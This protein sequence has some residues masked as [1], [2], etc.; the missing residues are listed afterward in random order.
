MSVLVTGATG[1]LGRLVTQRLLEQDQPVRVFT[2]DPAKAQALFGPRVEI[3]GGDFADAASVAAAM[4][5]IDRLFLLS[6]IS[7]TL[8]AEQIAVAE[9]AAAAGVS[10]IVKISGSDWTIAYPGQSISGDAH[11]DVEWRLRALPLQH[12]CLRPTAWMQVS[13]T[14]LL[15][16]VAAHQPVLAASGA[17]GIG[18]IDARDIADVAI[19]Q[20]LAHNIARKPLILTG[21]EVLTV[22]Q[23]AGKI[24]AILGRPVDVAQSGT[25][26]APLLGGSFEH[27]AVAQF[28]TLIGGGAAAYANTMVEQILGR[29]ARSVDAFL[30]EHFAATVALAG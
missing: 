3:A 29:P 26:L 19:D 13:L 6:P 2:R 23:V 27:R 21:P 28:I 8:A 4:A 25:G 12:V 7:E 5:G 14:N 1:R 15:K 20:L 17:A 18:F 22:G 30:A 11:A 9:A 10:R 16:Q 24:S